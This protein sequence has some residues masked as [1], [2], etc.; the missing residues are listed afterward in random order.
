[1]AHSLSEVLADPAAAARQLASGV[2]V[3]GVRDATG[4][5]TR[6]GA[7]IVEMTLLPLPALVGDGFPAED[8]RVVVLRDERVLT[9]VRSGRE[10]AFL[11]RN[12]SPSRSL[13][14]F[15][16]NDDPALRWLPEDGFDEYVT[17]VRRH[18]IFEEV[19]RR[20]GRWPCE[21]TPHGP[22][23]QDG[24]PLMTSQMRALRQQWARSA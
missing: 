17:A 8:V 4:R 3:Y 1:M 2:T 10:R 12:P 24:L 21:D 20:D 7:A 15:W 22:P 19:W 6:Y 14:L 9:Y 13:C 16:D 11:H 18:L 23:G 5:L